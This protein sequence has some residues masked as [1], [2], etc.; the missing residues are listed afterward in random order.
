M[1]YSVN[2]PSLGCSYWHS[3]LQ[4]DWIGLFSYAVSIPFIEY[5]L[6]TEIQGGLWKK[7]V[8][9]NSSQSLVR[10]GVDFVLPFSQ[11]EQQQQEQDLV[12]SVKLQFK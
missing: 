12:F 10:Q 11:Q 4:N 2:Y 9:S 7:R 5:E 3:E 8:L 1:I 6:N